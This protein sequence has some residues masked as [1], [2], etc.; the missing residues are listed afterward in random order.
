[1]FTISKRNQRYER[2]KSMKYIF[3]L[4]CGLMISSNAY[5]QGV[6]PA[7]IMAHPN[8]SCHILAPHMVADL[9]HLNHLKNGVGGRTVTFDHI[10]ILSVGSSIKDG[11]LYCFVNFDAKMNVFHHNGTYA[12][13][14]FFNQQ[15]LLYI[16]QIFPNGTVLYKL[17]HNYKVH[18][19]K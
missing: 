6:T 4:L 3:G 5:A 17:K 7:Q 19:I 8:V 16:A 10:K 1:M 15:V 13:G 9:P 12:Q 2:R 18:F 14:A 11:T